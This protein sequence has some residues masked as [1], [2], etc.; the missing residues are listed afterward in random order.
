MMGE[1]KQD[2]IPA[3]IVLRIFIQV[4]NM[5]FVAVLSSVAAR[6]LA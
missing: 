5:K 1:A 6:K 3:L 4:M 2:Q